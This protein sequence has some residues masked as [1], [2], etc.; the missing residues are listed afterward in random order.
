M[1]TNKRLGLMPYYYDI[2]EYNKTKTT[3]NSEL[4]EKQINQFNEG[5]KIKNILVIYD[6][7]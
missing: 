6:N 7:N 4:N 2:D 1:K 3:K 5:V